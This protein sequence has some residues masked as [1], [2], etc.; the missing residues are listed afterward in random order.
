MVV[1]L[2]T[3]AEKAIVTFNSYLLVSANKFSKDKITILTSI[4]S[5]FLIAIGRTT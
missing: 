5:N 2:I 4:T 3:N 1:A